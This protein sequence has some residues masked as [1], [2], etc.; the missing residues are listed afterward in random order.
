ME[1]LL[2]NAHKAFNDEKIDQIENILAYN[3]LP[4]PSSFI[5]RQTL[6]NLNGFDERFP[7][8]EDYPMWLKALDNGY[9][10]NF[11][12]EETVIYRIHQDSILNKTKN[13]QSKSMGDSG[14]SFRKKQL[15]IMQLKYKKFKLALRTLLSIFK[16]KYL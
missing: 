4:A 8:L 13:K 9:K 3:C 6:L 16:Y 14:F 10:F 15:L 11:F 1:K 5:E 2:R 7:M 12:D